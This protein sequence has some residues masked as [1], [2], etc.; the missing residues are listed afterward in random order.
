MSKAFQHAIV[1]ALLAA[2]RAPALDPQ[3]RISQYHKQYWQVEQGLPHSYVTALSQSP[4]GY[5]HPAFGTA[6]VSKLFP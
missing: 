1:I 2:S 5:L 4:D 6:S 3:L